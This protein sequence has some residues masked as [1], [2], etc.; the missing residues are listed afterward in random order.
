VKRR[1]TIAD[2][3]IVFY[4]R[5]LRYSSAKVLMDYLKVYRTAHPGQWY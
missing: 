1:S 4:L 3:P 2:E 5:V